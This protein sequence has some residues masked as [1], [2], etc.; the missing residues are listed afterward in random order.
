MSTINN[1]Y[2]YNLQLKNGTVGNNSGSGNKVENGNSDELLKLSIIEMI[3]KFQRGELSVTDVTK[4]CSKNSCQLTKETSDNYT[5][6]TFQYQGK[7]FRIASNQT[8][9]TQ[10]EQNENSYTFEQLKYSY[11]LSSSIIDKF[12]NKTGSNGYVFKPDCGFLNMEQLLQNV[13]KYGSV[14]N[15]GQGIAERQT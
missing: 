12:F 11:G 1:Y 5:I 7:T 2:N 8:E 3:S 6:Y 10:E 9:E 14:S 4:W 13:Y 15:Q